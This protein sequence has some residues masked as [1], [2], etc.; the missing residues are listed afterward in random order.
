M[1]FNKKFQKEVNPNELEA[2]IKK[3]IMETPE[4]RSFFMYV[5]NKERTHG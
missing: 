1:K 4:T 3:V 5:D 2:N